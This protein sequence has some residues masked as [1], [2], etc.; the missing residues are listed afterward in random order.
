MSLELVQLGEVKLSLRPRS[1]TIP[2]DVQVTQVVVPKDDNRGDSKSSKG[3]GFVE[4]KEHVHA[5][6][7]LRY[8]NNN[9]AFAW[10]AFNVKTLVELYKRCGES[11]EDNPHVLAKLVGEYDRTV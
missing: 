6:C 10:A 7:C 5:L 8:L 3:F 11:I 1:Q 2:S 4:F 9:P